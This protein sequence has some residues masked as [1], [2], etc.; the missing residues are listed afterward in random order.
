MLQ[1]RQKRLES[2]ASLSGILYLYISCICYIYSVFLPMINPFRK[3]MD[4][5]FKT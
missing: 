1:V 4:Y 2:L 3:D 5:Q